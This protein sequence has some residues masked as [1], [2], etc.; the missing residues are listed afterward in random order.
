[1]I[2]K[3][4][5][6]RKIPGLLSRQ[7]M[8]D[9]LMEEEYGHLPPKPEKISWEIKENYIR[10]FCGGKA[11]ADKVTAVCV[12]NGKEFS[13]PFTVCIPTEG[14]KHPFFLHINFRDCVPDR[15]MPT[16]EL[17]DNGFAVLSFGYEDVTK[18]NNDMTDG[19]AGVLYENGVRKPAD[20]GKIAMWAWAA[21]RVLDY[22]ETLGDVLDFSRSVVCGHSRLGKTALFAGA[23]DTRFQFIYSNDSGCSGAAITRGKEGEHV[24][25]ICGVFPFWFCENYKKYM[26]AEEGMPFDQHYLI[27][28]SAPRNVL[29]GSASEDLWADPVSEFLA[30]VA[31]GPAF[32]GFVHEDRLP[33]VG[34]AFFEGKIGYHL[35]KGL[36]DFARDDW[37][38]LIEFV[39]SKSLAKVR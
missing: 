15:Y 37:H 30:C 27:A 3:L 11:I 8:L 10:D 14:E 1:M 9:I 28:A 16:E 38:R 23:T 17:I 13:F 26:G 18:D 36:H 2:E 35:R 22:A 21:Q 4:L 34:E 31:A 7:E 20:A 29:V 6:E 33:K 24:H 5:E 12:V 32:G 19:L 25:V 39:N